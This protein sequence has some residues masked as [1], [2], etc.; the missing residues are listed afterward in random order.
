MI[1]KIKEYI[2]RVISGDCL[3]IMRKFPDNSIDCIVT[4]PPYGYSFMG[5]GWDKVVA[6]VE[7]WIECIRVLKPGSFAFIMSAPRQDVLSHMIVNLEQAGFQTGFTSIYW[8]YAS[9]FPK[10]SDVSMLIDKQECKKQFD[11]K[12]TKKLSK[13][14][15]KE[16]FNKEWDK[17]RKITSK[18]FNYRKISGKIGYQ[19]EGNFRQTDGMEFKRDN[20]VVKQAQALDGSYGGFQ[21]KPAVEI[22]LVVMKPLTEKT[23]VEQAMKNGKGITWLDD[24]RVPYKSEDD[25]NKNQSEHK[26]GTHFVN[27]K[28]TNGNFSQPDNKGRFPANLLV[29]DDVLN[30][31]KITKSPETYTRKSDGYSTGNS[32]IKTIGEQSGK[33]SLNYGDSGSFSRYFS[34]DKWFADKFKDLPPDLQKTFPFIIVPKASKGEK[35]EGCE[36]LESKRFKGNMNKGRGTGDIYMSGGEWRE[37]PMLKNIHPTCKP[38]KLMSYLITLGSRKGDIILDP[39]LGSGTTAIASEAIGRQWIGIE[40]EKEYC[41]IAVARIKNKKLQT[42]LF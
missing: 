32:G 15:Y 16:A 19:G 36:G 6:K 5:A 7:Y 26:G 39:F 30:D 11:I 17:F 27:T 31:G 9:G 38:I 14:E 10:A 8:T 37:S 12:L 22:V 34:L 28:F 23:Y 41:K 25:K 18:N 1:E 20:P 2:G 4:D 35:N 13:K 21:P 40:R 42:K 33:E 29:S 3:E 24:C